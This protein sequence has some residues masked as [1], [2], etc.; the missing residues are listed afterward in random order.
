MQNM[1]LKLDGIKG[2]STSAQGKDQ[3]EL[4]SWNH[5]VSMPTT[6][7]PGSGASVK[8]GRCVH[9][10]ITFNKY[11][12]IASPTLNLYCSGG[13]NI[14]TAEITLFQ[15]EKSD[16]DPV[17]Y[18]VI[19]LEDVIITN[20]SIGASG[21]ELPIETVTLHYNKITWTYKK[22]K[23]DAPGGA[24]GDITSGWDLQANKKV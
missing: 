5:G 24:E 15:A 14:K 22:Q 16:G 9:Q 7:S 12:D 13:N 4:L 23:H 10:D 20:I 11:L 3:I 6:H 19:K 21:G 18:Y 1:F 2:D 17:K 8:H